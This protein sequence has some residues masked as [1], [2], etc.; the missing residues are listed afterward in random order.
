MAQLTRE[1]FQEMQENQTSHLAAFAR[2]AQRARSVRRMERI[3]EDLKAVAASSDDAPTYN[4]DDVQQDAADVAVQLLTVARAL[5]PGAALWHLL[6]VLEERQPRPVRAD[7]WQGT[8][9]ETS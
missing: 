1:Q 8:C 9:A 6:L 3:L 4:L 2:R 7:P 5:V